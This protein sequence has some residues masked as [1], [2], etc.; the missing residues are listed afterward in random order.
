MVGGCVDVEATVEVRLNRMKRLI[1][2]QEK[3][4]SP[5]WLVIYKRRRDAVVSKGS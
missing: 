2:L 3:D 1:R 4:I 5:Q